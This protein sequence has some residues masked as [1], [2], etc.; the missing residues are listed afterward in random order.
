MSKRDKVTID[1][2]DNAGVFLTARLYA[3]EYFDMLAAHHAG[4]RTGDA[5]AFALRNRR[6]YFAKLLRRFEKV[7]HN[8][9]TS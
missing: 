1:F 4:A 2:Y 8:A 9:K 3:S 6:G 5:L 7:M